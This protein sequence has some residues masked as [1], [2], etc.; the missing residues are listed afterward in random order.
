MV[1]IGKESVIG[2]VEEMRI[3]A[4]LDGLAEDGEAAEAGIK[5]ENRRRGKHGLWYPKV[6]MSC[7]QR[8]T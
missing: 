4:C 8:M 1:A 2:D 5:D 7:N 6:G 3:R